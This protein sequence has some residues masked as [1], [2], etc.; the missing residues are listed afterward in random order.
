M[1][2]PRL[3][4]LLDKSFLW[5]VWLLAPFVCRPS[6]APWSCPGRASR[7]HPAQEGTGRVGLLTILLFC[8]SDAAQFQCCAE[9]AAHYL[10][11]LLPGSGPH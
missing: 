9:E 3:P 6:P 11:P 7:P 2:I 10:P 4:Y 5:P 8:V 1:S